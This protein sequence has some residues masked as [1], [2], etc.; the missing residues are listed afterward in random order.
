MYITFI[1]NVS[2]DDYSIH[3]H[4]RSL[5]PGK[6]KVLFQRSDDGVF[7]MSEEAIEGSKEFDASQFIEGSKHNFTIRLNTAVRSAQSKKRVP[8]QPDKVK[9]W[10]KV[11][12]S[13]AGVECSFQYIPEGIRVSRKG[14]EVLSF[15]SAFCF[16]V[17]TVMDAKKFAEVLFSGLGH[18]KG[19]GF[20]M[21]K[22]I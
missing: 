2:G 12:F 5:F 21:F 7:V 13:R 15:A 8:V 19:F 22:F 11:L 6:Q 1:P 20:G 14:G 18:A 9:Q 16:G 3:R 10:I 17:L 4:V